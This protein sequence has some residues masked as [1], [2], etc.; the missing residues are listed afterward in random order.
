MGIPTK[1]L[2]KKL[3]K[4]LPVITEKGT[5]QLVKSLSENG[6]EYWDTGISCEVKPPPPPPPGFYTDCLES[7]D[8]GMTWHYCSGEGDK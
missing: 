1:K 8:N 5:T 7:G 6:E 4:P 2:V 3:R